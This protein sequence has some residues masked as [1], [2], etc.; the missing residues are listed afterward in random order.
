MTRCRR[1]VRPRSWLP[2]AATILVSG[3]MFG[4]PPRPQPPVAPVD[5]PLADALQRLESNRALIPGGLKATGSVHARFPDADGVLRHLDSQGTLQ[6]C[7]PFHL[8]FAAT[9]P[10]AGDEFEL[11]MNA[12][13]CWVLV[14]RPNKAYREAD[15]AHPEIM[16]R[17]TVPLRPEQFLA[18]LGLDAVAIED[19]AQRVDGDDRQL[20]LFAPGQDGR[21]VIHREYWLHRAA[22]G[23]IAKAVFRDPDGQVQMLS[24]LERYERTTPQSPWL[25]REIRLVW[26][27]EQAEFVF[28]VDQWQPVPALTPQHRAFL[29]PRARGVRVD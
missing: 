2:I 15:V 7:P 18:A 22:P 1:G 29:S 8:R 4:C 6:V 11:G 25:P 9:H 27:G 12:S 24:H 26:P 5:V 21:A 14:Y 16:L 17:G 28:R 10:L 20:L 13:R 23:L 3:L 19:C